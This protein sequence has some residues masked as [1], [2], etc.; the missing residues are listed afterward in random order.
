M[1]KNYKAKRYISKFKSGKILA[2]LKPAML[3]HSEK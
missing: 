2:L 1:G 3:M